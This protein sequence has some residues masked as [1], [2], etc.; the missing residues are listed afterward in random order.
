MPVP[1]AAPR[2]L[3]C[4]ECEPMS[5]PAWNL[6]SA[7]KLARAHE[8]AAVSTPSSGHKFAAGSISGVHAALCARGAS[9]D[10]AP[11]RLRRPPIAARRHCKVGQVQTKLAQADAAWAGRSLRAGERSVEKDRLGRGKGTPFRGTKQCREQGRREV[12]GPP[13]QGST[14]LPTSCARA[15]RWILSGA[16]LPGATRSAS[17]RR[18]SILPNEA[19]GERQVPFGPQCPC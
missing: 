9:L 10:E 7:P 3:G 11:D 8:G 2:D 19:L 16:P 12:S 5:S 15:T 4:R 13:R 14:G 18:S 6:P 17:P 1:G